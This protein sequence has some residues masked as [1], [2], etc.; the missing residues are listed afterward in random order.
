MLL[1]EPLRG[2]PVR[3]V[4]VADVRQRFGR[5]LAGG[6]I[7]AQE[8]RKLLVLLVKVWVDRNG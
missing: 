8:L 3:C 1:K 7:L 2:I 5:Q 6:L 4:I